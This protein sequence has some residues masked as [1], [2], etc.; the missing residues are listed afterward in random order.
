M[1]RNMMA[2]L[3][4]TAMLAACNTMAGIGED[5]EAGGENLQ[6]SAHDTHQE[7]KRN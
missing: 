1:I 5:V 7:M 6:D 2:L 3:V 4:L